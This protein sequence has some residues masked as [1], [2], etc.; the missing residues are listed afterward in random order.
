MGFERGR[1]TPCHGCPDRYTACSDN[2]KKPEFLAWRAE[3]ETIRAN[4]R[5]YDETTA[6]TVNQVR[7]SKRKGGER[8]KWG[9]ESM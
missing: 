2:C 6:Y 5:K 4:R 7:R 9:K 1:D 3:L 8:R